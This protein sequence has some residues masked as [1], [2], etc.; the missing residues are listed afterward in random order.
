MRIIKEIN[1]DSLKITVFKYQ[2]KI[3]IKFEKELNEM[4]IKF[5]ESAL[6]E[7]DVDAFLSET[8]ILKYNDLLDRLHA[9]K[10][11]QLIKLEED[12][13]FDFPVII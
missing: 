4:T 11:N 7:N 1:K 9:F 12:K 13:G 6:E 5:R 2:E 8:E 10:T 3:S